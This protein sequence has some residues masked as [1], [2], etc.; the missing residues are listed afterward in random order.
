MVSSWFTMKQLVSSVCSTISKSNSNCFCRHYH[1]Y[2]VSMFF[3]F[4]ML[5]AMPLFHWYPLPFA[6]LSR[7]LYRISDHCHWIA[8]LISSKK[9]AINIGWHVFWRCKSV[10]LEH[11]IWYTCFSVLLS[12]SQLNKLAH[13]GHW[14]ST[15]DGMALVIVLNYFVSSWSTPLMNG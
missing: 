12:K 7:M 8:T 10:N 9:I 4:I 1:E 3:G 6:K 2:L 14:T 5:G 15:I 11:K 13:K